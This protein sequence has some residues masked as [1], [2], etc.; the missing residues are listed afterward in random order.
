MRKLFFVVATILAL[1]A[2][3]RAAQPKLVVAILVD[4][5]RYDY[6]ERFHHQFSS[7]GFRLLM[8]RGA[9]MTFAHYN[10]IPTV[11][12][13]G[14]AS[15]MSGSVPMIHGIIGN[16]W[17]D[18]KSGKDINCVEDQSVDGVGATAGPRAGLTEEF[19]R[20]QF[21]G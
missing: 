21:R 15:F 20:R 7:N 2:P 1:N 4:Q 11:T 3:A 6:L 17:Y 12:G 18:R 19:H 14:H 9:F 16:D 5:M 8:D 10:Y 13:P